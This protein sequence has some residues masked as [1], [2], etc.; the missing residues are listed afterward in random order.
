MSAGNGPASAPPASPVRLARASHGG[1]K[2][3]LSRVPGIGSVAPFVTSVIVTFVVE[4]SATAHATS[5]RTTLHSAGRG[6][7]HRRARRT[8]RRQGAGRGG[9]HPN[10]DLSG[11]AP[12]TSPVSLA[13]I[14]GASSLVFRG[15]LRRGLLQGSPTEGS[16]GHE[17][18]QALPPA[19][20]LPPA[21]SAAISSPMTSA[22][23][24]LG[25]TAGA[26][27]SSR[28]RSAQDW[29]PPSCV[30][31]IGRGPEAPGSSQVS[32]KSPSYLTTMSPASQRSAVHPASRAVKRQWLAAN[33]PTGV[34]ICSSPMSL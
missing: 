21:T 4:T 34:E 16:Q 9:R 13:A 18:L 2:H 28:S 22:P 12:V 5:I 31:A 14:E 8:H 1:S 17:R 19:P 29:S 23:S 33:V 15:L 25:V 27:R 26:S 10:P 24:S 11:V 20:T 3:P 7:G 6:R 32:S 30:Q